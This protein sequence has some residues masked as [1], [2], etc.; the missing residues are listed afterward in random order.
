[1]TKKP[2]NTIASFF[3]DEQSMLIFTLLYLDGAVREEILGIREE[4]YESQRKAKYWRAKLIK[5]I[6]P[7]YCHHPKANEATSKL[8]SIYERMI[9][10]AE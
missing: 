10:H 6:H 2:L 5:K 8:N 7:D 3:V 4:L 9:R 1:M